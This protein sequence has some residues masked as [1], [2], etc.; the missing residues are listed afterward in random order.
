MKSSVIVVAVVL[1]AV[2]ARA[3]AAP[4]CK[5]KPVTQRDLDACR[6]ACDAKGYGACATLGLAL[7]NHGDAAVLPKAIALLE[8]S[9]KGGAPLGCGGLGSVYMGGVGVKRD[10]ERAVTLFESACKRGDALSC[11]SL[12]GWYSMGAG[13]APRSK[14]E[15]DATVLRAAPWYERACKLGRPAACGFLAA[16]MLDGSIRGTPRRITTLLDR[17]CRGDVEVACGMLARIYDEGK[18]VRRD[19]VKAKRLHERGCKLGYDRSCAALGKPMPA[20]PDR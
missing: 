1:G 12:G 16:F 4:T 18:L 5:V 10:P 3:D 7:I 15:I 9:C 11:E 6:K 17:A 20:R 13:N 2:V 19:L 14:A 8:K